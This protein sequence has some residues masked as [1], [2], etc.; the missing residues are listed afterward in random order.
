MSFTLPRDAELIRRYDLVGLGVSALS[1]VGDLCA[2]NHANLKSYE[3]L[4]DAGGLATVKGCPATPD[5][6]RRRLCDFTGDLGAGRLHGDLIHINTQSVVPR[7]DEPGASRAA[8]TNTQPSPL[9]GLE[10][11][12]LP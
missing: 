10:K 2:Q 7:N 8:A 4:S 5:D 1:Q 12:E 9:P 11:R 6:R 3:T